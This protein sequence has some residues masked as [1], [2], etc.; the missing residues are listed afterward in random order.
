MRAKHKGERT[1]AAPLLVITLG[2]HEAGDHF[3]RTLKW[4]KADNN[5]FVQQVER[6]LQMGSTCFILLTP[7]LRREGNAELH[8][9]REREM[10]WWKSKARD[11]A[12]GGGTAV[13]SGEDVPKEGGGLHSYGTNVPV[14]DS[15]CRRTC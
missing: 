3:G 9:W 8:R 12:A 14:N 7:P 1:F 11:V 5:E 2:R 13:G 6:E 10:W 4:Q 15:S